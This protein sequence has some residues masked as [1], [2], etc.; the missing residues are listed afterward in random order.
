MTDGPC[1]ICGDPHDLDHHLP[2]M[3]RKPLTSN[4]VDVRPDAHPVGYVTQAEYD[5]L[6]RRFS[7][8]LTLIDEKNA[9]IDALKAER[10][11]LKA[12]R[13]GLLRA[14]HDN[15]TARNDALEEAAVV[16]ASFS[17]SRTYTDEIVGTIT[18]KTLTSGDRIA[19]QIRSLKT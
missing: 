10:D 6:N 17:K 7:Q 5:R 13:D 8:M 3:D 1:P 14:A 4:S 9:A 18:G 12:E 2:C 15:L 11:A 16:A 19:T